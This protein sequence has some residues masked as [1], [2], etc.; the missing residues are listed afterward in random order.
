MY[1]GGNKSFQHHCIETNRFSVI[2]LKQKKKSNN[3]WISGRNIF[4]CVYCWTWLSPLFLLPLKFPV[5]AE[6]STNGETVWRSIE[7]NNKRDAASSPVLNNLQFI[8]LVQ[9]FVIVKNYFENK[10]YCQ[11]S[12]E[13]NNKLDS[14]YWNSSVALDSRNG[15]HPFC[16]CT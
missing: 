11:C 1:Q 2:A 5:A 8:A 13:N 10:V 6:V 12:S 7:R 4:S 14:F 3:N 16:T 15:Q 9:I